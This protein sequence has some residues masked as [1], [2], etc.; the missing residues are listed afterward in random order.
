MRGSKMYTHEIQRFGGKA[1]VLFEQITA[2][3]GGLWH[4]T[5]LALTVASLSVATALVLFLVARLH[6]DGKN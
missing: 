5:N 1:A 4:G 2:W 6:G 3:L